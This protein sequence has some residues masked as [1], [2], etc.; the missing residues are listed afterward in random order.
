MKNMKLNINNHKD[1]TN[2]NCSFNILMICRSVFILAIALQEI[3]IEI[4]T[5]CHPE[6]LR[7]QLFVLAPRVSSRQPLVSISN[8]QSLAPLASH[9]D[10]QGL[11]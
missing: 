3:V 8:T 11:Y 5:N 6:S 4:V 1:L 7:Y 2:Q 10:S 9:P